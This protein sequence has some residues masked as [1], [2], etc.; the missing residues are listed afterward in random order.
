MKV[1]AESCH[2]LH[3]VRNLVFLDEQGSKEL[4]T[5]LKVNVPPKMNSFL[6]GFVFCLPPIKAIYRN[7]GK[8]SQLSIC[9]SFQ[10]VRID[11]FRPYP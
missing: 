1:M 10:K 11:I 6:G 9:S 7:F 2:L 4:E 5:D 8:Y 3:F